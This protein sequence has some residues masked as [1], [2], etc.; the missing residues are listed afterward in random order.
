MIKLIN[1]DSKY[2]QSVTKYLTN[3]KKNTVAQDQK[4]SMATSYLFIYLFFYRYCQL[5][6]FGRET[7]QNNFEISSKF[8]DYFIS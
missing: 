5:F 7:K 1:L 2:F 4:T 6:I 8:P 3:S